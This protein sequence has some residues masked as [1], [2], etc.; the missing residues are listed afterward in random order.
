MDVSTGKYEQG[1][2]GES[3]L[4]G[5]ISGITGICARPNNFKTALAVYCMAML[6]RA[7]HNS[8]AITYDSEGTLYPVGRFTA[9]SKNDDY[10]SEIDYNEDT[11]FAFTDISQ[12]T[13]DEFFDLFRKTVNEKGK[14]DKD[15]QAT[16][17]FIGPDG[18]QKTALYPSGGLIDS[19]SRM[20]VK[21]VEAIYDK[22]AIGES[23]M[24]TEAMNNGRA[25]KQMFNQLPQICA[26]T[27][28]YLFLTAHVKDV[29]NMEMYPTDK[30]N[31]SFM[32]KDT[33][34]EGVSGGFYSLPNNVW[35]ITSNKPLQNKDKMPEY[36]WDNSAAMHGDTDLSVIT[37]MNI[38]GKNGMSGIPIDIIVSQSEG[39][40]ESL[41]E[42]NYCK[43]SDR[44]GLGGNL[45]NYFMELLPE[46][47]LS[48]TT[49][50]QKLNKDYRLRR[51]VQFTAE[52]LQLIQFHREIDP[53]LVCDAKTLYDDLAAMGYDWDTLLET[54]GYWV[55]E[56]EVK[57]HPR[58]F[59]S[60][61]D[62]LRM[63]LGRYVPW[64][65][66]KEAKAKLKMEKAA[67]GASKAAEKTS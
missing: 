22:N 44:F 10:L 14:N 24:N 55:F 56:E 40:L 64:W 21:S 36:P 15:H 39:V 35:M 51:A 49:V 13:G 67:G 52:L 29:I 63:R 31:L 3:I 23:G 42:F 48:R 65:L 60:T 30:R 41:S 2:H 12:Y 17:P 1:I 11:Q 54:R 58:K 18:K 43:N 62:L 59:L 45:Q 28:T 53:E 25:K 9:V 57:E 16:T 27:G 66:D 26:R 50:R 37:M 38:R 6:R 34:L 47:K 4:N 46:T 7:C 19:L 20:T 33:V 32:K 5:G 61:M 8:H